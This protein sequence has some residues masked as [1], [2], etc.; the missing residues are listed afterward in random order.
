M[1]QEFTDNEAYV[2]E[3]AFSFGQYNNANIS[4]SLTEYDHIS[5]HT[6]FDLERYLL[7]R[8]ALSPSLMT[9]K[10]DKRFK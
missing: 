8:L 2:D 3:C 6:R 4:F 7:S 5:V 1:V 10:V 9:T